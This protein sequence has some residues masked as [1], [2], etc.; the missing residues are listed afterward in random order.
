VPRDAAAPFC[1]SCGYDFVSAT[2][3]TA[4]PP[5]S[6]AIDNTA[7]I[8]TDRN[9]FD[10]H[11]AESGLSFPDPRP[12]PLVIPLGADE[13]LIGRHRQTQGATPQI[14]LSGVHEDP[15][16]SHRHAV[17][18]RTPIGWTLTDLGST[19]GTRLSLTDDAIMPGNPM[20]LAPNARFY[21]G[22]WTCIALEVR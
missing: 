4:S 16:V 12:A 9:Y 21:V 3:K 6:S 1:E 19:N 7:V 13:I 2:P 14:D 18:R 17:L 5:P 22:A 20:A 11:G 10:A 8:Q 15:A